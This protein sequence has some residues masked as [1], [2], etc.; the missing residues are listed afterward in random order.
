MN[1]LNLKKILLFVYQSIYF[2]VNSLLGRKRP[3]SCFQCL[4]L[5]SLSRS[6]D[7]LRLGSAN[8]V[9]VFLVAIEETGFHVG[10]G[11]LEAQGRERVTVV[12]LDQFLQTADDL[13]VWY[14]QGV[15][16]QTQ[17]SGNNI[18]EIQQL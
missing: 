10:Q 13:V 8:G 4:S 9:S 15:D 5:H 2:W 14:R 11:F 18:A 17:H 16:I 6:A 1:L 7:I 12:S 3:C